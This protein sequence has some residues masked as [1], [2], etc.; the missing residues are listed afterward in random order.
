MGHAHLRLLRSAF[1]ARLLCLMNN[2]C[3][4][5]LGIYSTL[6][7]LMRGGH[8]GGRRFLR[9]LRRSSYGVIGDFPTDNAGQTTL[10]K[11]GRSGC[12]GPA[13]LEALSAKFPTTF[14]AMPAARETPLNATIAS[15]SM[16]PP[17]CPTL[18]P[19]LAMKLS[20]FCE[21]LR[22]PTAQRNQ[23]RTFPVT[24]SRLELLTAASTSLSSRA[25]AGTAKVSA[26]KRTV[27]SSGMIL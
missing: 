5:P 4:L 22:K 21:T 25:N 10:Q 9:R 1:A 18:T 20:I 24:A 7:G 17:V 12:G 23:T 14:P 27:P 19:M 11:A 8:G 26:S 15:P 13:R 2:A 6:C 16:E 3:C